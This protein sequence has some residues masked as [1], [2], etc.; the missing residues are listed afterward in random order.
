M[1]NLRR[2]RLTA[3]LMFV[4]FAIATQVI[5]FAIE[6]AVFK[7]HLIDTNDKTW[8]PSLFLYFEGV[9]FLV[10]MGATLLI[11]WLQKRRL[12]DYGFAGNGALR[13]A[14][15]GSVWGVVA[16][17]VLIVAI[18]ALGGFS[19]G[20]LAMTGQRLVLYTLAWLL[21]FIG[22]G[23]AEEAMFRATPQITLGEAIGPWPA[24]IVIS[25]IFGAVHYYLKPGEN[26]ADALSVG[27]LGLFMAFTVIRSGS[28]WYAV[29][30]HTLFDYAA[31][32]LYG[33]PNSGNGGKPIPTKLLTGT[34]HGPAWLTGGN[35]G[36]E[37][38]WLIF[39]IIAALFAGYHF[40]TRKTPTPAA[41]LGYN[42]PHP[43]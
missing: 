22:V 14:L 15:W 21:V 35:L 43:V 39:P 18:A 6:Y 34:Y 20:T 28:I 27:L 8:R 12:R 4:L 32:F 9:S 31:L 26:L 23:L 11:A 5:E 10:A 29:G 38:S 37:A 1:P 42:P 33:A 36:I 17:T 40:A 16:P 24:A 2:T 30:F 13:Q 41:A 19:F 25:A 7:A 3:F